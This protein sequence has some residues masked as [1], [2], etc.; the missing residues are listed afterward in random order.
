MSVKPLSS[1]PTLTSLYRSGT[2]VAAAASSSSP[3]IVPSTSINDRVGLVRGDITKLQLDAIVNAAN[4]SLLGGGGADG[5][6]HRAAGPGLLAECRTLGGCSTGRA[7]MTRGYELPAKH[8]IHTV[9]PIYSFSAKD[10]LLAQDLLSSCYRE[11]LKVAVAG[12][13]RTLAFTAISTGVYGYPSREAARV[14]CSTVREFLEGSDG[15]KIDRVVFVTFETKEGDAY[16]DALP[17]FFPPETED[18]Q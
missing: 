18:S 15:W 11:S 7:K 8:V 5:A 17:V 4:T 10:K 1:I 9:G 12:G 6:I 13:V 14:A 3:S 16:R 2:L